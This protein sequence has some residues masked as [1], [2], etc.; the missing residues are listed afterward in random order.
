MIKNRSEIDKSYLI[1]SCGFLIPYG[2]RVTGMQFAQMIENYSSHPKAKVC[3][4]WARR[5]NWFINDRINGS[6]VSVINWF[7]EVQS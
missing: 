2:Q 1:A 7:L 5:C 4:S 3:A 6:G